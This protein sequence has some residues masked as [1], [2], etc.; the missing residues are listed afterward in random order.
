MRGSVLIVDDDQDIST[1]VAEVLNDEGFVISE[2]RDSHPA[3]IQAEIARLEPDVVL[4]DGGDG[5]DYG[6]SWL[7]AAWMRERSRPIP[8]IMFTAHATELAEAQL[9]ISER[10]KSAAFVGFL[11]KPFDLRIL[12]ETVVRVV[13]EPAAA[14]LL[15]LAPPLGPTHSS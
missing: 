6:Y 10:S 11:P 7:N 13:E 5:K 1:I 4:L 12:V 9:G 3:A 2:L 15:S 14:Q 8:V